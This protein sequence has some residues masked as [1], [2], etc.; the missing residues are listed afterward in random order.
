M[1]MWKQQSQRDSFRCAWQGL[2]TTYRQERH[3]RFH[4]WLSLAVLTLAALLRIS[5]VEWLFILSAVALVIGGELVNTA[6]ETVVDMM[7]VH[8]HP[9]AKVAK[10]IGAGLVVC[11]SIYA[12]VV[13]YVV[14]A[15]KLWR[16]L[17]G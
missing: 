11:W 15:P 2:K 7:T 8:Y 9:M 17:F 6:I 13:G 10:D 4:C 1:A 16:L 14:F 12:V 5:S 3:F